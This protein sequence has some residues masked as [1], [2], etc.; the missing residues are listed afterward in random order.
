MWTVAQ[1]TPHVALKDCSKEAKGKPGYIEV[2]ATKDRVVGTSSN[3]KITVYQR[4]LDILS[5]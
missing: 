2:F 1:E 4:K 3:Q 5:S